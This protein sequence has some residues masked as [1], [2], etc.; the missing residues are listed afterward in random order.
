MAKLLLD[1]AN[2]EYKQINA[3][4][5]KELALQFQ[6]KKAPTMFIPTSEGFTV[7]DNVS[8]IKKYIEGLK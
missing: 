8:D 6:V 3:V 7:L 5:N 4:E 2:I 1:K